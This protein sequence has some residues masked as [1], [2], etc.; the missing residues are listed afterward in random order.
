MTLSPL[1]RKTGLAALI[2]LAVALACAQIQLFD[3]PGFEFSFVCAVV[4][5]LVSGFLTIATVSPRYHAR[6]PERPFQVLRVFASTVL[7]NLA[8]LLIPFGAIL[9]NGFFVPL[10]D[11]PEGILWFLLL[12]VVSVTFTVALGMFCAVHYRRS[13]RVFLFFV[14]LSL[15]YA[16]FVGY[17]TPA[18]DSYNFFYGYFPGL[19]YDELI[20]LDA[21]LVT[22]RILT[23][24]VAALLVWLTHILVVHTSPEHGGVRKGFKLFWTLVRNYSIPA[25]LIL[26][27]L[28]GLSWFRCELGW[29]SSASF[30]QKELGSVRETKNFLIY[31]DSLAYPG[32]AASRLASEH[33]FQL[34]Q[35]LSEFSLQHAE[36]IR[37][38]VYPNVESKRS[39]IGAG[40]TEFAKPWNREV[41]IAAQSVE[42]AL[43]HELVHVVAAP[44]G[45]PVIHASL[46]PGLVEGLAVAVD[47][48]WGYRT[49]PQYAAALQRAELAP[50]IERLMSFTGFAAQSSSVSYMLAGAFSRHLIDRYGMRPL[51]QVYG[52]GDYAG[53]F[54]K[55]LPELIAE[56]RKTLDS[57]QVDDSMP[58]VVDVFFRRP[59]I[60][61]K[62]C[63]RLH[64]RRVRQAQQLFAYRR[65][66]EA[67]Q[68][69][70][71]LVDNG[72][73][74]DVYAGLLL[75]LHRQQ[76]YR[77]VQDL[78][79]S[80]V[81]HGP[82][83]RRYL[84]LAITAGDAAWATNNPIRAREL[85]SQVRRADVTPSLTEAASV[86]LWAL[87]ESAAAGEFRAYFL[88]DVSDT[89]RTAMLTSH[90]GGSADTLARFLR[91]RVFMRLGRYR[92]AAQLAERA[93]E[94]AFD[95]ILEARRRVFLGNMLVH[96]GDYQDAR[97]QFWSSLNY[98][99]RDHAV[100]DINER[101]DRCEFL[102]H[103]Q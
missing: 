37:S 32:A 71:T 68:V 75:T 86:R 54:G 103:W 88:A 66:E 57:V 61:G 90:R 95:P 41:H 8:L 91:A 59:A 97:A 83:P 93:G 20:P 78:Y 7:V 42:S 26:A 53:A 43:R 85:Y 73:G 65:Y 74:Y 55:T 22:F 24:A 80:L 58:A 96:T 27:G 34:S 30:L 35:I 52:G 14:L 46:S 76:E 69:Y 99:A 11:V 6:E 67:E 38:Y 28:T 40:E 84:P 79:D 18:I 16:A 31:F 56:W 77:Q 60:F 94:L 33:E 1:F 50:D 29:E 101:I 21:P 10:C 49:L 51:L 4:G 63:V 98:D 47:G 2:Y 39:L 13:R 48:T 45:V 23:L 15:V 17:S 36:K 102:E 72:G 92:D 89:A 3:H 62:V 5:T 64:A 25:L 87:G 70:R 100:L 9:V 12:P 44:F 81:T 19:S 82:Y